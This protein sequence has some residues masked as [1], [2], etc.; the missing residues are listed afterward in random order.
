MRIPRRRL[1]P[2]CFGGIRGTVGRAGWPRTVALC[3]LENGRLLRDFEIGCFVAEQL[4][5]CGPAARLE[6]VRG[7]NALCSRLRAMI[8]AKNGDDETVTALSLDE[9]AVTEMVSNSDRIAASI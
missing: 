7:L 9:E 8:S 4:A 2:L 1:N 3:S 5:D 6:A